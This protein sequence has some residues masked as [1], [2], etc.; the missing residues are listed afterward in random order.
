MP[1]N[2]DNFID[3][4]N[5][6][7]PITAAKLNKIEQG[8][9]AADITNPASAAALTLAAT[10]VGRSALTTPDAG[11]ATDTNL[12]V[13][14]LNRSTAA[15]LS[16]VIRAEAQALSIVLN[17][18]TGTDLS[19]PNAFEAV[20]FTNP[21]G[22]ST[23]GAV[24]VRLKGS[25]ITASAT[26]TCNIYTDNA[27][28]PGTLQSL[29]NGST[30][31]YGKDIGTTYSPFQFLTRVNS[32]GNVPYWAVFSVTGLGGGTLTLDTATTG[33]GGYANSPDG[34]TWTAGTRKPYIELRGQTHAALQGTSEN[35][36]GVRGDSTDYYGMYG[37]S[38]SGHGV[39]GGSTSGFGVEG[40]SASGFA[41]VKGIGSNG[42]GVAGDGTNAAGVYGTSSN[43]DGVYGLAQGANARGVYGTTAQTSGI[44]VYGSNNGNGIGVQG[45]N[46]NGTGFGVKSEGYFGCTHGWGYTASAGAGAGTAPPAPTTP[47]TNAVRGLI[48]FGT[49]TTPTAGVQ[50]V[51]AFPGSRPCPTTPVVVISPTNAATAALQLYVTAVSTTG[52]SVASAVAPTAS[53]A[54]TVY[55]VNFFSVG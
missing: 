32:A 37:N 54:N 14:G 45:A 39:H 24:I 13:T 44:G 43:A 40:I 15:G 28:V 53:Q 49:G 36:C 46:L 41:G 6:T 38:I 16:G 31:L 21:A 42:Y 47:N 9:A 20:Q 23:F 29:N 11:P 2:P 33:S 3:F 34:T 26:V 55:G 51:F 52:F 19:I 25:G 4:P 8:I 17:N 27:G 1:F 35:Y 7:T 12:V 30:V 10:V 50:V 18:N 22:I 5:T 48:T